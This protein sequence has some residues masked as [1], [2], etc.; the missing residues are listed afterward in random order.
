M[1]D[2]MTERNVRQLVREELADIYEVDLKT[3]HKMGWGPEQGPV[4]EGDA[5]VIA[6]EIV[7]HLDSV[8]K[9]VGDNV[10]KVDGVRIGVELADENT[11][12]FGPPG[13]LRGV[14]ENGRINFTGAGGASTKDIYENPQQIVDIVKSSRKTARN[15]PT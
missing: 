12:R 2:T 8:G 7:S 9:Q 11:V 5:R 1:T 13:S 14:I 10:W 6:S 3:M 4:P 15:Y